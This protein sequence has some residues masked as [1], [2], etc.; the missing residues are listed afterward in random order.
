MKIGFIGCG[1]M[2]GALAR[3]A[4]KRVPGEALL[5]CD[6][7]AE[8]A[9]R[10]AKVLGASALSLAETAEKSDYLFIGVKPQMLGEL[11]AGLRPLLEKRKQPAV[12]VSMA[13]GTSIKALQSM[14]GAEQKIIR[15]MPNTPVSVG[16][17]AILYARSAAVAEEELSA[18][19]EFMADAGTLLPIE[20]SKIDA[21]SAISGCGPA[22][23]CLFAE[24][25]ADGGVACGL[26]RDL[27]LTLAAQTLEGTAKLLRETETHPGALKDAVCSPGGTTVEGVLA[28]EARA[29]RSAV[30][31]AVLA[32]YRKTLELEK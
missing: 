25:L 13:A 30:S 7:S 24:A 3:A 29:F 15:I 17:G 19:L 1:N 21:A 11:F 32:A 26:P 8:K 16:A 2:G 5:L 12:L 31:E 10:L 20:E 18:F 23:V 22:Y 4:A 28:L 9:E 6:S 27:S 14:A